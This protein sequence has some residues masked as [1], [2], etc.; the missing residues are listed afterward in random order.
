MDEK[1]QTGNKHR[2]S[3][4]GKFWGIAVYLFA[5]ILINIGKSGVGNRAV[6]GV[7]VTFIIA[8]AAVA[9]VAKQSRT[10]IAK[11]KE[12]EKNPSFSAR[13]ITQRQ[14]VQPPSRP[15]DSAT[16]RPA[17]TRVYSEGI[18]EENEI[19]DRERRLRQLDD[20]Y[21]NGIIDKEEYRVLRQR[22]EK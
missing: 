7:L 14:A 21:K 16:P 10:A 22:Y 3:G 15:L 13:P 8:F 19:R 4:S 9:I 1:K 20:F 5:L 18:Q 17:P 2:G 12:G 11:K 6:F